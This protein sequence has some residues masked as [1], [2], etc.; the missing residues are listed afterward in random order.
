MPR[1]VGRGRGNG[2]LVESPWRAGQRFLKFTA[3]A[4]ARRKTASDGA[5]TL[6]GKIAELV[7]VQRSNHQVI[8][9]IRLVE[10]FNLEGDQP[11]CPSDEARGRRFV[12]FN[13]SRG[14]NRDDVEVV[15]FK[16]AAGRTLARE[17]TLF[18]S[19]PRAEIFV[20]VVVPRDNDGD[21]EL[22]VAIGVLTQHI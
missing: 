6:P 10:N 22:A 20:G 16:F 11:R 17:V 19:R 3:V 1:S 4:R 9:A 2:I 13:F 18:I 12:D 15:A 14:L 8:G 21:V 7:V 5:I